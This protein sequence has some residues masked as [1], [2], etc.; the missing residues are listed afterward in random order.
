MT[1]KPNPLESNLGRGGG[2]ELST[3]LP[4]A[5]GGIEAPFADWVESLGI[6][7]G[8]HPGD[9]VWLRGERMTRER[10]DYLEAP[11]VLTEALLRAANLH[12]HGRCR[13]QLAIVGIETQNNPGWRARLVGKT[14]TRAEYDRLVELKD[15]PK[16]HPR[17]TNL[18]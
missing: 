3:G 14:I 18:F 11:V 2:R 17:Q 7:V 15:G 1:E 5:P 9:T 8:Q 10:A 6:E 4:P 16:A 13:E 12:L